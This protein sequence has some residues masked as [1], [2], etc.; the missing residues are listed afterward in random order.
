MPKEPSVTLGLIQMACEDD[1]DR[2]LDKAVS[3]L[4]AARAEGAQIAC[5]QELFASPYFCQKNDPDCFALAE[6]VP[7]PTTET[8]ARAAREQ[9]LVVV[10]SLFEQEEDRYFNTACVIDADGTLLGKYRK[11]HIPDDPEN[12][13]SERFYFA[14]G[15]LGFPVFETRYATIG[16]QVC[17]DQWFPEGARALA[18]NGAEIIFYPT[19]IGWQVTEK[20]TELGNDETEAWITVQRGHAIAN[21]VFIAAANRTGREEHIDFWGNSF[22][23]DPFGRIL[24]QSVPDQEDVLIVTCDMSRIETVR[25]DWPFLTARRADAY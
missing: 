10:A 22:V 20:D 3:R 21:G 18:M 5:L 23:S 17:W 12:H 2:N 1:R 11:V 14:P 4:I 13:Y 7:G 9:D 24:R 19:A 15:D 8:L 16:V 6:P 25:K